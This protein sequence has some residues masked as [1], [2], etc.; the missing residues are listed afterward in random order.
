VVSEARLFVG[1]PPGPVDPTA[2]ATVDTAVPA[3]ASGGEE[4][5]RLLRV[6]AVESVLTGS[7]VALEVG[8]SVPGFRD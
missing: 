1:C 6:T 3:A 5:W 2:A 7:A 4:L 8:L